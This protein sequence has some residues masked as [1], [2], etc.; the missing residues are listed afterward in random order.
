MLTISATRSEIFRNARAACASLAQQAVNR[1]YAKGIKSLLQVKVVDSRNLFAAQGVQVARLVQLIRE[2]GTPE[3][4]DPALE[5]A[6]SRTVG[7]MVP[8][9]LKYLYTRAK[10]KNDRSVNFM[11]YTLGSMLDV[12]PVIRAFNGETEAWAKVRS[13]DGAI[14]RVAE[15]IGDA[16]DARTIEP[17]VNVGYGGP[18]ETLEKIAPYRALRER[19]AARDVRVLES[20]MSLTAGINVGRGALAFGVIMR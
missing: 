15:V 16:A 12:K 9:D 3:A 14:E 7:F 20:H 10:R 5:R 17:I 19:L 13:Y 18:D 4:I 6:I 2:L 11:S 8:D 1:R